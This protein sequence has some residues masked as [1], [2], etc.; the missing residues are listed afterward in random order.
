VNEAETETETETSE[1]TLVGRLGF[2]EAFADL[3]SPMPLSDL[4]TRAFESILAGIWT[5]V[6]IAA[7]AAALRVKGETPEMLTG[8]ARS[9]RAHMIAVDHGLPRVFDTCGTGGDGKHTINVSTAAA[10][11]LAALGV[12]VAKHGNRSVSSRSGSADVIEALGIPL[13]VPLDRQKQVLAT[14][15]ICFLMAPRHHPALGHASAARREL[16]IRTIFNALGPLANPARATHQLVGV[17]SDALR[18]M[19][20]SALRDLGAERAWI[21]HSEDGMDEVSPCAP[22]R[23]TVLQHGTL[24]EARI[25]PEDFGIARIGADALRGGDAAENAGHILEILGGQSH[26]ATAAVVLNA[27][28]GLVVADGCT[29]KEATA[30]VSEV[31]RSGRALDVLAA[32]RIACTRAQEGLP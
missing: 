8:A 13:D 4:V 30:R 1:I 21:V 16:G 18:P 20:A 7:F 32:W 27:A 23:V 3:T 5:T 29:P 2:R 9:L 10:L 15:G 26:R 28:A 25:T 22:T 24:T 6:E 19:A 14:A 31:L 12:P 11:I 17:Y